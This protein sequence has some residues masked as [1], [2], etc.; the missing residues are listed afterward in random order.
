MK[1]IEKEN[2]ITLLQRHDFNGKKY[3]LEIIYTHITGETL[4]DSDNE[5]K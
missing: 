2:V 3:T 4:P 1:M 5:E